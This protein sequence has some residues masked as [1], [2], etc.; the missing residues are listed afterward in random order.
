[1]MTAE[2]ATP[3]SPLFPPGENET[4]DDLLIGGMKLLQSR[5]GYRF[6]IDAVLLSMWTNL[7][8]VRQAADLGTGSGVIPLLLS[9]RS[10]TLSL[11]ALELQPVL[12]E[13][14]RKN[15]LNNV[16]SD[17]IRV[18]PGDIRHIANFL[19]PENYDLVLSNPPFFRV[20]EG[21]INPNP[22]KA[23]ARHELSVTLADILSAGQFLLHTGGRIA[24]ILNAARLPELVQLLAA[25]QLALRRLRLVHPRA[26][27]PATMLLAEAV[28]LP[29]AALTVDPPLFIYQPD[30]SYT[31]E[32]QSWYE[33]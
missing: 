13:R 18:I 14:A 30:G 23:T 1:M 29:R 16:L 26:D 11:D 33:R 6:S 24:L 31:P 15:V 2:T 12:A 10:A 28:K 4:L 27:R 17:R 7:K 20:G 5:S 19:P 9:Q 8:N 32:I 25:S 3:V 22:E 21:I